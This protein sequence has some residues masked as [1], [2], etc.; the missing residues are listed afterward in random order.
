MKVV[1][2]TVIKYCRTPDLAKELAGKGVLSKEDF[3]IHST[4]R[5]DKVMRTLN[6]VTVSI[7]GRGENERER[8]THTHTDRERERERLFRR[9]VDAQTQHRETGRERSPFILN[10]YTFNTSLLFSKRKC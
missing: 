6:N 4:A 1:L 9:G 8:D 2:C 10:L 7:S 3:Q 5:Y